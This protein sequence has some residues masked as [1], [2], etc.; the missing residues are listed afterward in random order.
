MVVHPKQERGMR[1][2]NA[3]TSML[4]RIHQS[5]QAA[6]VHRF[7]QAKRNIAV[8]FRGCDTET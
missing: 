4:R 2:L 7:V 1:V 8:T 3:S 5:I 6:L